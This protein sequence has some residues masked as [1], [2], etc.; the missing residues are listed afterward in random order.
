MARGFE[1]E[2]SRL[3]S[4]DCYFKSLP[5][6][7]KAKRDRMAKIL[8]EVGLKP[9]VPDGGYF[10]VADASGMSELAGVSFPCHIV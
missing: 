1:I 2:L 9:I 3:N 5:R 4:D 6:E 10:M 8:L 7:L